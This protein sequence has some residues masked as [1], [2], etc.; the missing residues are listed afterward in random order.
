[1]TSPS[2]CPHFRRCEPIVKNSDPEGLVTR[3]TRTLPGSVFHLAIGVLL[4]ISNV[5][6]QSQQATPGMP[7]FKTTSTLVFLD[8]TV[9]DKK[10]NP[11]VS[12]LTKDDFTITED[13]KPQRIFSFEAPQTHVTDENAVSNNADGNA[14]VTVFVLDQ[15]NS[16]FEDF[17]YI[18][19]EVRRFL[20]TQPERLNSP[21]EMM[22]IGN[23]YLE[24]I[25]GYTRSRT[26]LLYAL[27]H[28]PTALPYKKMNGA[29]FWERFTQS[30]DALQQIALQNKGIPGRKNIIW[31]GHGGPNIF[32]DP[33]DFPGNLEDELKQYVH[34]TTNMLV[35][36]RI[37]L[38][39]IYP[40]LPTTGPAMTLSA[41]EADADIG[42]NDPF[43]GDI[44]FGVFVNE[45]GGKLFFN[46]ND[47]DM[48]MKQSAQMGENYYTLTYQ[49]QDVTPNG[50]F[51]RIRVTLRDPRLRTVTKAGY[52]A[53]DQKEQ[54]DPRRQ[55]M[56]KLA[57]AAQST[58]PFTALDMALYGVVRH[59]DTR[60]AEF[61]VRLNSK[62]LS[63]LPTEDGKNA[64]NLLLAAVSLDSN[65]DIL[66]SKIESLTIST[67]RA[68][69]QLP[70]VAST[71]NLAIRVPRKTSVIRVVIE[72][73]D[74]GRMGAA[75]ISRKILELSPAQPTPQPRITTH[76]PE[77]VRPAGP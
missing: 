55:R 40:G 71:F 75:E 29:F 73:Q 59:P 16:N 48:E 52:F 31:V 34:S 33:I 68:P 5:S 8:V 30:I 58:I 37:S 3:V 18:R 63:L 7:T 1:M 77:Y 56:M 60:T 46:R 65:R 49:P 10:G 64:T 47:V 43:A 19:Y 42:D 44:N 26:D 57:E 54:L 45:T 15:L 39:V 12:G 50:K 76:R 66:A 20:M 2:K 62:N 6:A 14:P 23:Q 72:N 61:T 9:L 51:R 24:M 74:G 67:A 25:Q 69:S 4:L 17:A 36:A 32:L 27:A 28:L 70:E 38:F 21:A 13:K 35:N 53:P 11:V 22:V 41:S